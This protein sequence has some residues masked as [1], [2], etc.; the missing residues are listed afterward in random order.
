MN[1]GDFFIVWCVDVL[2]EAFLFVLSICHGTNEISKPTNNTARQ[3]ILIN[4]S[5]C[6]WSNRCVLIFNGEVCHLKYGRKTST[7]E[8]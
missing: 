6:H 5:S 8:G 7:L 4:C 3:E 2:T 1:Y